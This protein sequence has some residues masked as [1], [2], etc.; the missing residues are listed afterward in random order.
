FLS[1][2]KLCRLSWDDPPASTIT[3][4]VSLGGHEL[5]GFVATSRFVEGSMKY[6]K[7][8][9]TPTQRERLSPHQVEN[10]EGGFLYEIS[11]IDRLRRFLILG[12]EGGTYYA[13]QGDHPR[14]ALTFLA[15]MAASEPVHYWGT[16]LEVATENLAPRHSTVL[17][18]L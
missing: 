12:T 11:N 10:N 17:Y 5:T 3:S 15:T 8:A 2:S 13:A 9:S 18:A 14:Q 1:G 16:L 4:A 6:D 7:M